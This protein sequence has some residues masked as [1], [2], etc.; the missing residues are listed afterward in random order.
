MFSNMSH[1]ALSAGLK[2][3]SW[4]LNLGCWA[5]FSTTSGVTCWDSQRSNDCDAHA[6]GRFDERDKEFQALREMSAY[7]HSLGLE[8]HAGHGLNYHNV[9]P[10]AALD[11]MRELN[12]GHSIIA[13]SVFVGLR[14]AVIEMKRLIDLA[15][16]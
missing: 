9:K 10:V 3:T 1:Q 4:P 15:A 14:E 6:E 13:R 7:A 8:V 16:Q 11:H 12:I 2:I 5:N